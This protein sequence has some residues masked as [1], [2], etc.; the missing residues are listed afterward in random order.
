MTNSPRPAK[1]VDR[2]GGNAA[3]TAAE[4]HLTTPVS[5]PRQRARRAATE[6]GIIDAFDRLL[7]RGGIG[8]LGVNALIKEAGVGKKQVYEYFG[9]LPGVAVAWV[10]TRTVWR[11]LEDLLDEPWAIFLLRPPAEKLRVVNLR[12]AASLRT[13]PRLCE[14]LSGEFVKS[15]EIKE[16]IDHVRQ[17]VRFDFERVLASDPRLSHPDMLSLNLL[18]YS[19]ATYLGMRAHHQPQFFGFDLSTE[20]AWGMVLSMFDR[21]LTMTEP[22]AGETLS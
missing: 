15:D 10:R 21:A 9:G 12:Y 2:H 14:L 6:E 19:A 1:T 13:N 17:L 4:L 5:R 7:A 20:S 8:G 18:A 3:P 11:S 22:A 16:A